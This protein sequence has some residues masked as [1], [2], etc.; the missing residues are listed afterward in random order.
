[1]AA[2][3]MINLHLQAEIREPSSLL[4]PHI[5]HL[6]LFFK[7]DYEFYLFFLMMRTHSPADEIEK[8]RQRTLP[9]V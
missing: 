2:A 4:I 3:R 6:S 8:G 9:P 5:Y 1:M 7:G